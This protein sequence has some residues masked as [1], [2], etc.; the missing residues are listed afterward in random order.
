MVTTKHLGNGRTGQHKAM[1]LDALQSYLGV[2]ELNWGR[3][4]GG[5]EEG[6]GRREEG[7][8]RRE[9]GEGR[10]EERGERREEGDEER[11]EGWR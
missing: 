6:G 3:K 2:G 9:E 5:G 8:G 10:R 4:G 11:W 7:G 1:M